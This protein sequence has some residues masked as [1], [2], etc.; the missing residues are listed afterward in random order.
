MQ[1]TRD[2]VHASDG[3]PY[4]RRNA[5]N[6]RVA[7][8]DALRRLRLDKG[9]ITFED[10]VVNALLD[11]ICNS[12]TIL[13]FILQVVPNAEPEEWL[14]KQHLLVADRPVVAG[15]L[16]FRDEPQAAIPK[17]SSIKI[18]RY[19][20]RTEEGTREQLAF[21]PITIEGCLYDQISEAVSRTKKIVE[22]IKTLTAK[23]LEAVI[24]PHETL[25]EIIT[26]AG[27]FN[28]MG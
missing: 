22:G 9:I 10:E 25:H 15:T 17:R 2:I 11:T 27:L 19:Q 6:L 24:Y 7:G 4:V 5:Q 28:A 21:D 14:R 13:K 1:K 26:N 12:E 20:T 23:G 3:H 18:Y 8:D 16:L